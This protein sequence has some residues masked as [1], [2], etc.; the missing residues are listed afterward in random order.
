MNYRS[1]LEL[2]IKK[3]ELGITDEE[4]NAIMGAP[5]APAQDAQEI[6]KVLTKTPFDDMTDDE[7][8][9]YATPYYEELQE[10]RRAQEESKT[11]TEDLKHG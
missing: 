7:I 4:V 6:V 5:L 9:Y 1:A 8:L 10:K 3:K 11:T 2:L